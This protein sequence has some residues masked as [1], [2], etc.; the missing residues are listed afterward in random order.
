MS[1]SGVRF[2]SS[3][4]RPVTRSFDDPRR[5]HQQIADRSFEPMLVRNGT[6]DFENNGTPSCTGRRPKR[7]LVDHKQQNAVV[8]REA[9]DGEAGAEAGAEETE[10]DAQR[11]QRN[12]SPHA[13][14]HS[15]RS[16]QQGSD[17]HGTSPSAK[18]LTFNTAPLLGV[19]ARFC[20]ANISQRNTARFSQLPYRIAE[21]GKANPPISGMSSSRYSSL[22]ATHSAN[23][24]RSSSAASSLLAPYPHA[25]R[26]PS[27]EASTPGGF[28][29]LL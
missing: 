8:E 18:P 3:A 24:A 10:T 1:R 29:I 7:S 19:S 26:M 16:Q 9:V 6:P 28:S 23:T 5:A 25:P 27:M 4:P 13:G 11:R 14:A 15:L 20:Q 22:S 2:P 17:R 12:D 21:P